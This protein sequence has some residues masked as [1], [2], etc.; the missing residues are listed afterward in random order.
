MSDTTT[1][2]DSRYTVSREKTATEAHIYG[3]GVKS[4]PRTHSE[5]S[6]PRIVDKGLGQV[7]ENHVVDG[8]FAEIHF[9]SE[10]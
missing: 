4:K 1:R 7:D 6:R 5:R 2:A 3:E 8:F 10:V 9:H